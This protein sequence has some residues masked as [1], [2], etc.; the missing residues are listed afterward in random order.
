MQYFFGLHNMFVSFICVGITMNNF[1]L[2][3]FKRMLVII[4][5]AMRNRLYIVPFFLT[6]NV[7]IKYH[8]LYFN[9]ER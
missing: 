8:A 1:P 3:L 7:P 2:S 4:E 9:N 6:N 5:G